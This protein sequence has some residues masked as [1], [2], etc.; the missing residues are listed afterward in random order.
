MKQAVTYG[1]KAVS[2]DI[3]ALYL[4]F[5]SILARLI[6]ICVCMIL[7]IFIDQMSDFFCCCIKK[8]RISAAPYNN[9]QFASPQLHDIPL[10]GYIKEPVLL[11][12]NDAQTKCIELFDYTTLE[13][14]IFQYLLKKFE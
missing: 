9:C 2:N 3:V 14:G 8:N 6:L 11:K 1:L 10:W 7:I 4:K 5:D 12:V 13:N